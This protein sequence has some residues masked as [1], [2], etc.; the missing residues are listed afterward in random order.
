MAKIPEQ[1]DPT[2]MAMMKAIEN[3]QDKTMRNYLGASSIGRECARELWYGYNG[4]T[5]NHF[6]AYS[7]MNFEDGHR[8]EDLTAERLR[9]VD[10]IELWTHDK[11]GKQFGFSDF[12]GQ[13]RGHYDGII[14]G[15][16]QAPKKLHVW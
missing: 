8:T 6:D 7:L 2:L 16:L 14:K 9:L 1:K 13:F 5:P 4:N 15:L 12:D 10:G 11:N 3:V